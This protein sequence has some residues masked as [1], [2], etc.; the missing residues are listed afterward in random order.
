MNNSLPTL[1]KKELEELVVSLGEK[2]FGLSNCSLGSMKK[3][4]LTLAR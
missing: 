2:N 4:P 1:N 3:M